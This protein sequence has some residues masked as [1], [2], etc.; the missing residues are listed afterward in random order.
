MMLH[1]GL[2][3]TDSPD[4][5]CTTYVAAVLVEHLIGLGAEF[6][7]YPTLLRLNPNT[8]W[9]T[10]GNA[11]M[12]LRLEIDESLY[13]VVKGFIKGLIE[14]YG[15][16]D[17]D[18][19]NPGVVF[20]KGEVPEDVREYSDSVV[21]SLVEKKRAIDLIKKHKMD[22]FEYKNGRGLIGA[23]AAIGGTLEGDLTYELLT[24]RNPE[25]W[26]TT[27][28]IDVDSIIEMNKEM[29]GSMFNN[30]DEKGNPLI[31]PRGPDPVLYGVRGETPEDVYRAMNMIKPLEPVE[32]WMICRTNQGTDQHFSNPVKI[33][34]L[35]PFNPAVV[36]GIVESVPVTI[37][38]GHVIFKLK[39]ETGIVDCAA[40]EPTGSFR[41]EVRKLAIGDV[42]TVF[43]GV[44]IHE[45]AFTLN[46]EKLVIHELTDV[47]QEMNPKCPKCN[48]STSSMGKGQGLRCKR[49]GYRGED[50]KKITVA[51]DRDLKPGIYLPDK[52]AHR[53]LTKPYERYGREKALELAVE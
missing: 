31:T 16:F 39:D 34:D 7:G 41:N 40:Y 37:E 50:L 48:G 45:K 15:E 4:G 38:G 29:K 17:C 49:C 19:T 14:K 44:R 11:A 25:K 26:G 47:T 36:E 20:L 21:K 5:G 33:K 12:C 6:K 24:Y 30:L 46:L 10:R 3:D 35:E 13:V 28:E 8:P 9:K 32:R 51:I 2:D 42:V 18:N 1:I 43:S 52:G 22:Y 23:L 27:R 53:H